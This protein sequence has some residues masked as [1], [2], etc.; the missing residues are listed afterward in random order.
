MLKNSKINQYD[1][2]YPDSQTP[3]ADDFVSQVK[4]TFFGL[5]KPFLCKV[6]DFID[7]TIDTQTAFF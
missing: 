6:E 3:E 4:E 5:L 2:A 1:K 7:Q